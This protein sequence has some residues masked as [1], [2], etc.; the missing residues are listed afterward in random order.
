VGAVVVFPESVPDVDRLRGRSAA[1]RLLVIGEGE[2]LAACWEAARRGRVDAVAGCP[3]GVVLTG[4]APPCPV[5]LCLGD[6]DAAPPHGKNVI[7]RRLGGRGW[8]RGA[9]R[10]I[11]AFLGK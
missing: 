6:D 3:A 7:V 10:E 1:R 8:L 9:T 2:G 4:E 5:L 11:L